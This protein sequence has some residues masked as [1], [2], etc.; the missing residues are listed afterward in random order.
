MSRYWR[1]KAKSRYS[2]RR[3]P[4]F[5]GFVSI[6]FIIKETFVWFLFLNQ[7]AGIDGDDVFLVGEQRV[8][9]HLLDFRGKAE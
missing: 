5:S 3:V 8:D 6:S 9:V 2:A 7:N 1:G 4:T